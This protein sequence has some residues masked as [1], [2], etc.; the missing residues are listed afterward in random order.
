METEN[1]SDR[2]DS[3]ST[4]SGSCTSKKVGVESL[5]GYRGCTHQSNIDQFDTRE[6]S[7]SSNSSTYRK[8]REWMGKHLLPP[9]SQK[10]SVFQSISLLPRPLFPFEKKKKKVVDIFPV[11]HKSPRLA[12]LAI[13]RAPSSGKDLRN[14]SST[15]VCVLEARVSVYNRGP[16]PLPAQTVEPGSFQIFSLHL[17][18]LAFLNESSS[19][20]PIW[21]RDKGCRR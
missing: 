4:N 15:Y 20:P 1:K 2:A 21:R 13:S 11:L 16:P 19:C 17:F 7:H 3:R 10:S 6:C 8:L 5:Q 12:L 14:A 18:L 9:R